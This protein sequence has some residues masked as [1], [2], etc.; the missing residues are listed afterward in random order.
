M[1]LLIPPGIV[2]TRSESAAAGRW[3]DGQW[4]R[5]VP[6]PEKMGG[7][8]AVYETRLLGTV[9]SAF[10][11]E[12]SSGVEFRAYGSERKLYASDFESEPQNITPFRLEDA[13]L[14]NNPFTTV[15]ASKRVVVAHTNHGAQQG[16]TVVFS[17][18]TTFAGITILDDYEITEIINNDSY[19]IQ[20][21][22]AANASTSGG[23]ASVLASYEIGIGSASASRATGF[24]VGP[25][26]MGTF[27][28][29]R[30]VS[31][32]ILEGRVWS[33]DNYGDNLIC[34]YQ[35]GT[36]YLWDPSTMDR[37]EALDNAP[38]DLR[39]VF[40]TEERFVMEL[41]AH[42]YLRWPDRDDPTIAD[43]D[44]TNTANARRLAKGNRLMCG[45][46]LGGG[47][48]LIWTDET[49]YLA[50]YIGGD[51]IYDTRVIDG[52]AGICGPNAFCVTE[53][54]AFWTDGIHLH[55]FAAGLQQIP[56][57]EDV[58]E[59]FSENI[60]QAHKAKTFAYFNAAKREVWFE[61]PAFDSS[62]PS[63]Y[64]AVNID[65]WDWTSG[66]IPTVPSAPSPPGSSAP[67]ASLR[68]TAAM[69]SDRDGL[70]KV[71]QTG[72]VFQHEV[73]VDSIGEA[74]AWSI[75]SGLFN[76]PDGDTRVDLTG[77]LLDTKRHVGDITLTLR[78][79]HT[80]DQAVPWTEEKTLSPHGGWVNPRL[81][82]A[83]FGMELEQEVVGGDYHG[84]RNILKIQDGGGRE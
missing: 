10:S 66:E 80:S 30:D 20:H 4:I 16:D 44:E 67:G 59:W 54:S 83:Y 7:C 11:W 5:F 77:F 74:V 48:S 73:G 3:V 53:G 31:T 33:L 69:R 79:L 81:S 26:G 40:V 38:D 56:N 9:R 8:V 52:A 50:Q 35:G 24:G 63:H 39:A 70:L 71:S 15:S 55:M 14:S 64:V 17:G 41:C 13:A 23:G 36:V 82:G 2:R 51:F 21:S 19:A 12:G 42:M 76:S 29:P 62:E 68:R 75:K 58:A 47:I 72:F 18:A 1:E 84:G 28:T 65:R 37:A 45:T 49:L 61:F 32:L 27:G 34:G 43:P 46:V 57:V 60:T 25:F 22:V 78:A 6:E